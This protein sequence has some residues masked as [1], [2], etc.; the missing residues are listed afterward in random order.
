MCVVQPLLEDRGC[1]TK[2]SAVLFHLIFVVFLSSFS[3]FFLTFTRLSLSN[4]HQKT[5]V[6]CLLVSF[7]DFHTSFLVTGQTG[8]TV[9]L[10]LYS[11]SNS[12]YNY[13]KMAKVSW[14]R[15]KTPQDRWKTFLAFLL[16]KD[17]QKSDK[18]RWK[19]TKNDESRMKHS[20]AAYS[21]IK[22]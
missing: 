22:I 5:F 21:C 19:T 1:I 4:I 10:A 15:W 8:Q 7:A 12:P 2:Q 17:G 18:T 6:A 13:P 16:A 3:R 11:S 9:A 14:S 20:S